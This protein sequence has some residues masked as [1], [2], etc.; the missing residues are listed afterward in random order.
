[1][2]N[3]AQ[4]TPARRA[5]S[6]TDAPTSPVPTTA[7]RSIPGR[8]G[9]AAAGGLPVRAAATS[10]LST[11][12]TAEKMAVTARAESGPAFSADS[13]R[14]SSASRSASIQRS[15]AA[16][17]RARTAATSSSRRLSAS[18]TLPVECADLGAEV[19]ELA[20]AAPRSPASTA[21]GSRFAGGASG[22]TQPGSYEQ[23]GL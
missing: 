18:S 19:A 16:S 8:L 20:H 9:S 4:R 7:S 22:Q 23:D 14:S 15:P 5:A 17:F 10:C 11:S 12:S 2:S 3:P 13:S 1:M 21:T 6:A